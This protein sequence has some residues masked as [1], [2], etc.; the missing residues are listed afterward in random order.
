MGPALHAARR[1]ALFAPYL[2]A[3]ANTGGRIRIHRL[4]R[5]LSLHGDVDLYARCWPVELAPASGDVS[6]AL[7]L[8]ATRELRLRGPYLGIAGLT[9]RRAREAAP[10]S[11]R[12]AFEQRHAVRPYSALIACHSYGALVPMGVRGVPLVVDEHNIESR[13]ARAVTPNARAEALRLVAWER[14]VW[15]RADLV[16]AVT[17]DDAAHVRAHRRGPVEV[18]ANGVACDELAFVAPSQRP[19]RSLLFV[20]SMA[21]PP[22]VRC[23]VRLARE[24]LPRVQRTHPDARLIVCGRAPSA[25]VRALAS[26]HVEVTGTVDDTAPSLARAGAYV[27][28]LTE[29]AGSSL[30]V[31]EAM[32]AGV[33]LVTTATGARGFALRDG[34]HARFAETSDA[35]AD[36]VCDL[37]R[38]R[39][40][41][42]R[43]ARAAR[44]LAETLDWTALGARFA[45]AVLDAV[46]RGSGR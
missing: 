17:D 36:A 21:H 44:A 13:Y 41:A 40:A 9:S 45:R 23:A 39:E 32:A 38:D 37:W 6:S 20:G 46:E 42:D 2:P 18:I 27:N 22:N 1:F 26:P 24:V 33:P 3:P 4:A 5:A 10:R 11:L 31:P 43:R 14:R 30:K 29:G 28:L 12:R 7:S 25:E 16:T 8:Y 19:E 15:Q 35:A 34:E